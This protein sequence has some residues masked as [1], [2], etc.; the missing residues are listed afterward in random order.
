MFWLYLQ[1]F[2]KQ[3]KKMTS[4]N[5][6]GKYRFFNFDPFYAE[7]QKFIFGTEDF[8]DLE[9]VKKR[10][11]TDKL[12][13]KIKTLWMS[14]NENR[15][16][17]NKKYASDKNFITAYLS[18][19][20]L[21]NIQRVFSIMTSKQNS[22]ELD[23]V[24]SS[25]GSELRIVDFG[26]GPLS[27]TLGLLLAL[28]F[29]GYDLTSKKIIIN[30]VERSQQML[31]AG[32]SFLKAGFG[33]RLPFGHQNYSSA[34]KINTKA[35]FILCANV[36]NELAEKHRLVT[37]ESLIDISRGSILITEPGQDVHSKA[38]GSLR[39]D[40]INSKKYE[41][42]VISPCVNSTL[43]PLSAKSER[44]DWCWFKTMWR[45]P[46]A[47]TFIDK[48]T[49]LDH[50]QLNYSYLHF[51]IGSPDPAKTGWKVVSDII[52]PV[53]D[54]NRSR[55]ENYMRNNIIEGSPKSLFRVPND[56][57]AKIL[58]CSNE[59]HLS[60]VIGDKDLLHSIRRGDIITSIPQG[61]CLCRER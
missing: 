18:S 48:I 19:F 46:D 37:L 41:I 53:K 24:F 36:F 8:N 45:E 13:H 44:P 47:V 40:L 39:N 54:N 31:E 56:H 21:P 57:V 61:A 35:D 14:F 38:L 26:S 6:Y 33:D 49:G 59:G 55:F 10:S 52:K 30:S 50:R 4:F 17:L 11:E 22:A 3:R 1:R 9:G 42:S 16:D 23:R 51:N 20:Y 2:L 58:L 5:G 28:D 32:L 7:W 25:A 34:L 29:A 27:A 60:S 43:C 15:D 12:R